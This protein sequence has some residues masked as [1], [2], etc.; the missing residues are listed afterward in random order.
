MMIASPPE[1]EN[2][3]SGARSCDSLAAIVPL[4]FPFIFFWGGGRGR[5][6]FRMG[7]DNAAEAWCRLCD[8]TP[9]LRAVRCK[10][11][12]EGGVS[13]ILTHLDCVVARFQS[14]NRGQRLGRAVAGIVQVPE[15]RSK[16]GHTTGKKKT[17]RQS[18]EGESED[19]ARSEVIF[20]PNTVAPHPCTSQCSHACAC[21]PRRCNQNGIILELAMGPTTPWV[22]PRLARAHYRQDA[23]QQASPCS[24]SYRFGRHFAV[25]RPVYQVYLACHVVDPVGSRGGGGRRV[26]WF[27]DKGDRRL[28]LVSSRL[29]LPSKKKGSCNCPLDQCLREPVHPRNIDPSSSSPEH[30]PSHSFWVI[31]VV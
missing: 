5:S 7:M 27:L 25:S 18:H 6:K 10:E 24:H 21:H 2:F 30:T 22:V 3:F 1:V 28:P 11:K 29:H 15:D 13:S 12:G 9:R 20:P 23:A 8:S 31:R 19:K 17:G 4:A 16:L 14:R 26:V